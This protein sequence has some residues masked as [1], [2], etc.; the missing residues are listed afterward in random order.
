MRST[1]ISLVS[2]MTLTTAAYANETATYA[3]DALGRL[4]LTSRSSGPSSGVTTSISYDPADNRTTYMVTGSNRP[5]PLGPVVVVPLNG[6]T[7]IP[8]PDG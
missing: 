2:M 1:A 6:F 7:V 8:I 5:P 4:V 3:Y